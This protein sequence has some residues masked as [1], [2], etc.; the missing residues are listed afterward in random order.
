MRY[1]ADPSWQ[2]NDYVKYKKTN[3]FLGKI[4][5]SKKGGD[6]ADDNLSL[7]QHDDKVL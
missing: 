7:H 6:L 3:Y 1:R 2:I 5:N 4:R